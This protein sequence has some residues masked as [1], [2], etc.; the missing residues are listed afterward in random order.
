[1]AEDFSLSI[2][3]VIYVLVWFCPC[4]RHF[5]TKMTTFSHFPLLTHMHTDNI[6]WRYLCCSEHWKMKA[7]ATSFYNQCPHCP[8]VQLDQCVLW[9]LQSNRDTHRNPRGVTVYFFSV[10]FPHSEQHKRSYYPSSLS[11]WSQWMPEY[12]D[13]RKWSAA[14]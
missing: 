5:C 2:Y 7:R 3:Q 6:V 10:I 14:L 11:A 4:S 12:V 13:R 1:M 9:I 8:F